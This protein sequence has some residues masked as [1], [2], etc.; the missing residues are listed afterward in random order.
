MNARAPQL[1]LAAPA[2]ARP[3][4]RSPRAAGR[5]W[6]A[7]GLIMGVVWWLSAQG[8]TP[9]PPLRHPLDWAAHFLTYLALGYTLGRAT[10]RPTLALLIAVYFGAFDEVHQ[11]FVPGR[12]A[13]VQDWLFDLAGAWL[14]TRRATRTPAV[15][16]APAP[17]VAVLLEFP[18]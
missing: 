18:G 9:G 2:A 7:A 8:D 1:R 12:D 5:W 14:G 4:G 16:V 3:A 6:L 10:G 17:S 13:G 15:T 11:A